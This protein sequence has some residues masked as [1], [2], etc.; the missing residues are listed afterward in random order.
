MTKLRMCL[1]SVLALT[2]LGVPALAQ[3]SLEK[4]QDELAQELQLNAWS[5]LNTIQ[6][7]AP[8]HEHHEA[9][10]R[11]EGAVFS[12]T[13]PFGNSVDLYV[14]P[15]NP[16]PVYKAWL[17]PEHPDFQGFEVEEAIKFPN[18][19]VGD[20]ENAQVTVTVY[21]AADEEY[22][23]AHSDWTSFCYNIIETADNAY[24]SDFNINWVIDSYWNWNSNGNSSSAILSDLASDFSGFGK[25]LVMGFTKD[26]KFTAG[27]IAYVYGSN[28]G[29]GY[30]VCLD[31]GT[32]ST[33]YAL[34]HEIGH[35]YSC[36][37]D[38][39]PVVCMMNYTYS[40]SVDYFD[41]AHVSE[42]NSHRNWFD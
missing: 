36:S 3:I 26:S 12:G 39:D 35:N 9:G 22:R 20:S 2:L 25:G 4:T 15:P 28:P 1:F 34:R 16:N 19:K 29:T 5:P 8:A 13:D 32:S 31:Q 6:A 40:Y 30:S 14:D 23:A 27:G 38:F 37:H 42:V 10:K 11:A 24:F 17:D 33:T 21:V 18:G 7:S 41:S